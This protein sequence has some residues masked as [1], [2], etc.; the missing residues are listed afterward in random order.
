MSWNSGLNITLLLHTMYPMKLMLIEMTGTALPRLQSQS[1]NNERFTMYENTNE[2]ITV[3][4][5]ITSTWQA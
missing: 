1:L 3:S 4:K 5:I 2:L